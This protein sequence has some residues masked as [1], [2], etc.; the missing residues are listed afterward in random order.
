MDLQL[1]SEVPK[2]DMVL[3]AG[4]SNSN[5][6]LVPEYYSLLPGASQ[7]PVIFTRT[8]PPASPWPL[9]GTDHHKLTKLFHAIQSAIAS[10]YST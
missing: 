10:I 9:A 5:L 2:Y 7:K 1:L 6:F 4:V 3:R 8:P